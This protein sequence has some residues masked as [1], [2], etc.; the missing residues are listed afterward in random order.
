MK[1][2]TKQMRRVDKTAVIL[3]IVLAMP[4]ARAASP[5]P[6]FQD[7][8]ALRVEITAPFSRLINER[9]KDEEFPGSFSF[10]GPDGAAVELDLQVR[11]RGKYRHIHCDFPP[12][13]LNFKRSQ[14]GGTLFDRQ[15][16]LK[17]VVHCKDSGRYQQSVLR[18]YLAYRI[19]NSLTDWSFQVRLLDVTYV[20]S[21]NRRP[22]MVRSAF[23]IEHESRLADR[24]DRQRMNIFPERVGNIQADH[25]NL[26]SVFQY[27][28][29]NTDLSPILGSKGECCHNYALFGAD[30]G[31]LLAIPYDFDMSGFVNTPYA[32]PEAG[33]GIDN[34][35]QRLYQGFCVNNRHVEAS[36]AE[37]LQSRD[38]LY[39]LV[40]EQKE[41]DQSVRE[42]LAAYMDEFYATVGDP[43]GVKR[44]LIER[45]IQK[46]GAG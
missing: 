42:R 40:A 31:P 29:G 23:L 3:F 14:V 2:Q 27:L 30:D 44:E 46:T 4:M 6:L 37:F 18:E 39:A 32:A 20:D 26:T 28:L 24:L 15:N 11:A 5:D 21:E 12:L 34:V 7:D 8:A 41:L 22:R 1:F 19:L 16:K 25:L 10:K 33:L 36:V 13:F 35:R 38:T 45:C 9:P 43:Q 17:M